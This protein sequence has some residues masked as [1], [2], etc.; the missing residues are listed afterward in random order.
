MAHDPHQHGHGAPGA[1]GAHG[2]HTHGDPATSHAMGEE[3]EHPTWSTYW[4][5]ALVLTVITIIEVWVYYTPFVESRLF[6]PALLI[7]SAAKFAIVV[8]YY[9]HLKY[10]HRLFRSLFTGPFIIAALTLVSLM[11][12]FGKLAMRLRG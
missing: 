10:D 3:H 7:M 1:H 11:F 4:K 2:A 5:V 12:L 9:M 8:M 6:V